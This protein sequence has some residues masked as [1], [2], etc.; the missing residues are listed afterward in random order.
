MPEQII[1]D[2]TDLTSSRTELDITPW[3]R[4][5][6]TDW[7]DS[8]VQ[9]YTAE[10]ERGEIPVDF[11]L[12]NRTVTIP[13]QF[14]GDRGGTTAQTAR[15][16][17]QNKAALFQREGGWIKRIT[18]SGGTVYADVVEA[19]FTAT[20]VQGFE[21]QQN[22]DI[23]PQ[24]V[25]TLIPDFYGDEITLGDHTET[26]NPELVFTETGILGDYP[27]RV[28]VVVDEDQ[29]QDQ[30]G[31]FWC[32]RSRHYDSATTAAL[33]YEAESLQALDIAST[34]ALSGASGG[35][36]IT[37]GTLSTN[38]TPVVG[39][40]MGGTAYLTHTGTYRVYARVYSTSGT[41]VQTR[42]VWDTGDLVNP[43]ENSSTRLAGASNFYIVDYGEVRLDPAPVGTHRWQG[44]I[45]AKG[46][47]GTENFSV[48]RIWLVNED[49]F[50]GT[51]TAPINWVTGPSGF[52][53]NYSARD[54]FN[55][56]AGNLNAKVMPVGGT[57]T[58]T[59]G[60]AG[61]FAVE[62]TGHTAQRTSLGNDPNVTSG[63]FAVIGN[64]GFTNQMVGVDIDLTS[65]A[66]PAGGGTIQSGVL[67]RYVD[68][69]NYLLFARQYDTV[70]GV[71]L[72]LYKN[73][74]GT[75]TQLS[76][77][78]VSATVTAPNFNSYGWLTLRLFVNAS[79]QML[80]FAGPKGG[81]LS[82]VLAATDSAAATGG[83]LASGKPGMYDVGVWP[84][85]GFGLRSY[86]NFV[87]WAPTSDSVNFASRSMQLTDKGHYRLDSGG[88][89]Y[90]PVSVVAGD[91]AR[92]PQASLESR[93][94]EGMVKMSRGDLDQLPDSGIDDLSARVYYRPSY[95]FVP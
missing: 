82:Y 33:K 19:T 66:L 70:N 17:I 46:D 39:T 5:D 3:I 92:L 62:S 4:A 61:D 42:F 23:D 81:A 40:N 35:T 57:W 24:L 75:V 83:A 78:G 94:V 29:G 49:E 8:E 43:S 55:Q 56:T 47:V 90:G 64:A 73:V 68:T 9:A 85:L 27:G 48:D 36:V 63:R 26:T 80:A 51:L 20:S 25:L 44:Q 1:L 15:A 88:T 41:T 52:T 89:A 77:Q 67:A 87:A 74:G 10:M 14:V 28:R 79:G 91:L 59:S 34:A 38:W 11:R 71:S 76:S 16:N 54:E 13:L 37:H 69:S 31:M 7:G 12:P 86:D 18:N 72:S 50:S 58:T 93:T 22:A 95:L 53:P 6:G 45:Q 65:M 32:F 60:T 84:G 21:S 30:R 2:P